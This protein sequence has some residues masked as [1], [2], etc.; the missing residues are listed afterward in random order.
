MTIWPVK[1][2]LSF[3]KKELLC[4]WQESFAFPLAPW[5][6]YDETPGSGETSSNPRRLYIKDAG[7][8]DRVSLAP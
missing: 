8:E 4:I 6:V 7:L 1:C 3:E 5:K 2:T